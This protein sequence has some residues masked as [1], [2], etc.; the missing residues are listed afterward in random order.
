MQALLPLKA[1]SILKTSSLNLNEGR[2]Q[3]HSPVPGASPACKGMTEGIS[4][5]TSGAQRTKAARWTETLRECLLAL[6]GP[7]KTGVAGHRAWV[8]GRHETVKD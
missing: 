3:V 7:E 8:R 4:K 5:W 1:L 2:V 6:S